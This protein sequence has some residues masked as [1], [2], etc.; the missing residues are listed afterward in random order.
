MDADS[1][2]NPSWLE[3]LLQFEHDATDDNDEGEMDEDYQYVSS[4]EKEDMDMSSTDNDNN[5]S[6]AVPPSYYKNCDP[7]SDVAI[8]TIWRLDPDVS[9]TSDYTIIIRSSSRNQETDPEEVHDEIKYHV[10]KAF[11]SVGTFRSEYLSTIF[12]QKKKRHYVEN[13]QDT[14]IIELPELAANAFPAVLDFIYSRGAI[15]SFV[16]DPKTTIGAAFIADYMDIP[17]VRSKCAQLVNENFPSEEHFHEYYEHALSLGMNHTI[18]QIEAL[19]TDKIES[20]QP[21]DPI[22][23]VLS[24]ESMVEIIASEDHFGNGLAPD[25]TLSKYLSKLVYSFAHQH[26]VLTLEDFHLLTQEDYLPY[27]DKRVAM[28]LVELEK[29]I[30][31]SDSLLAVDPTMMEETSLQKRCFVAIE[32]LLKNV[33]FHDSDNKVIQFLRHNPSNLAVDALIDY[34]SKNF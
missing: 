16:N 15:C 3:Y 33:D 19:V 8:D 25:C 12:S 32:K 18:Q 23:N 17:V 34:V 5:S 1:D 21:E 24:L 10:H 27:I 30:A 11:L 6:G 20:F 28:E 4:D 13:E 9:H 7:Q 14:S 22:W 29:K 26:A 31:S 2:D